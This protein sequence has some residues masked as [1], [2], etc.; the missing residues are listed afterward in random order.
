MTCPGEICARQLQQPCKQPARRAHDESCGDLAA[1]YDVGVDTVYS[2][3]CG[4]LLSGC[5]CLF[6]TVISQL[7]PFIGLVY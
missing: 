2:G 1:V 4:S 6:L 5:V 7:L 3:R